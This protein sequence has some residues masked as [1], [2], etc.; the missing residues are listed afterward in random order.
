M[1]Q[2]KL[3]SYKSAQT[4]ITE[5]ETGSTTTHATERMVM[6]QILRY[7]FMPERRDCIDVSTS[8]KRIFLKIV[9]M[10]DLQR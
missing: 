7:R 9:C 3:R 4:G 2:L 10:S 5:P 1:M 8:V 6:K